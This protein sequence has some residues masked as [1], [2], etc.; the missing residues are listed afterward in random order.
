MT[1][2]FNIRN[3][4]WNL[5]YPYY[6]SHTDTLLEIADSLGLDLSTPINPGPT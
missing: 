4:D 1:R 6:S 2:D 5:F 3:N